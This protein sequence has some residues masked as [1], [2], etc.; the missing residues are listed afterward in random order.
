MSSNRALPQGANDDVVAAADQER[1]PA[2]RSQGAQGDAPGPSQSA[3]QLV[4]VGMTLGIAAAVDQV[5]Q[6]PQCYLPCD[7]GSAT[8]LVASNRQVLH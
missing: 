8:T 6:L 7:E 5:E 2:Q 3:V 4:L 1:K